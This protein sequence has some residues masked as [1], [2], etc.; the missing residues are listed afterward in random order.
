MLYLGPPAGIARYCGG[1]R[2]GK[3]MLIAQMLMDGE[4]FS[5]LVWPGA[6]PATGMEGWFLDPTYAQ[7]L[8]L[9]GFRPLHLGNALF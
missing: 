4:S 1:V 7:N 2:A 5:K 9:N 8:K 3:P 6:D